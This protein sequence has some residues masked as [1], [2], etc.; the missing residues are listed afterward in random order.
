MI[1]IKKQNITILGEQGENIVYLPGN[2]QSL[3]SVKPVV[4]QLAKHFRVHVISMPGNDGVPLHCNYG[5][6]DLARTLHRYINN[7]GPVHISASSYSTA[8]ALHYAELF[9]RYVKSLALSSAA[10]IIP[11]AS[12]SAVLK[13]LV[14]AKTDQEK[15]AEEYTALLLSP[16]TPRYRAIE[17]VTK[18][19]FRKMAEDGLT[20]FHHNAIR[21]LT[22]QDRHYKIDAPTTCFVGALD[23]F[24]TPAACKNLARNIG[25]EFTI[26]EGADHMLHLES[27][28]K[29]ASIMANHFMMT[30]FRERAA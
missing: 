14:Y 9:P 4:S 15:F 1:G 17:K 12:V 16:Q 6:R 11:D 24:T 28:D 23:P 26:V 27:P 10:G 20:C 25:A 22:L 19:H 30:S 5:W 21:L 29:A 7:I 8:L 3:A 18:S 2:M 13:C